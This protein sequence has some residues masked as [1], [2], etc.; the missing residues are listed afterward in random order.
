MMDEERRGIFAS[1]SSALKG[2]ERD[3]KLPIRPPYNSDSSL[4]HTLCPECPE[5]SCARV[6]EEEIILIAQDGT[7]QLSFDKRGCTF[8]EACAD[9]CERKVLSDKSVEYIN[10]K[11]QIDVL[12]CVAWHQ[13]MCSSCKDPCLEDAI[14]FLGLFR[15]EIDASKCTACGWCLSVCPT[16]AI[17]IL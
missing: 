11:V 1:L 15:P 13:V 6:C 7:P 8:C 5:K 4:F 3:E 2:K 17:K 16:E 10:A 14:Q 9:A 12:K